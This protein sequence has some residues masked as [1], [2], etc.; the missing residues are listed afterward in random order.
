MLVLANYHRNFGLVVGA[1]TTHLQAQQGDWGWSFRNG[2][3][4]TGEQCGPSGH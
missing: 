4:E 3:L 1:L 2:L